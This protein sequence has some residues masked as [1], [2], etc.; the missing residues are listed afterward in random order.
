MNKILIFNKIHK[1]LPINA[2]LQMPEF[3][4]KFDIALEKAFYAKMPNFG[5]STQIWHWIGDALSAN[6]ILKRKKKKEK[7]KSSTNSN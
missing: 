6:C 3:N 7:D 1:S 5:I 4:V 2:L